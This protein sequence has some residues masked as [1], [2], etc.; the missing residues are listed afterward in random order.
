MTLPS[1]E[2]LNLQSLSDQVLL[3][4]ASSRVHRFVYNKASQSLFKASELKFL[5]K[6]KAM[7]SENK[8][9]FRRAVLTSEAMFVGPF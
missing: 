5:D 9:I 2:Y 8:F 1:N 6:V 4:D 3:L 7:M